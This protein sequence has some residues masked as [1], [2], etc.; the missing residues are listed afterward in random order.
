MENLQKKMAELNM[1]FQVILIDDRSCDEI[2]VITQALVK[3]MPLLVLDQRYSRGPGAAFLR[4]FRQA[5][6]LCRDEDLIVSLEADNTS[7][8][9]ILPAMLER[10]QQRYDV[11]LA[12]VYGPGGQIVG[13]PWH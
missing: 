12:S 13:A 8:L 1:D 6:P 7:D 5:L 4:G 11:V 2:T 9:S 10:I 3:T